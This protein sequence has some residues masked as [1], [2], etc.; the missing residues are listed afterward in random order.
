MPIESG[1]FTA[2]AGTEEG[3]TFYELVRP[4]A[5]QPT[6]LKSGIGWLL[7]EEVDE[8]SHERAQTGLRETRSSL[9]DAHTATT[10]QV[11][12]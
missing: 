8:D 5:P 12:Q 9:Q 7:H 10:G 6:V 4:N 11:Q 1:S 3:R 2:G